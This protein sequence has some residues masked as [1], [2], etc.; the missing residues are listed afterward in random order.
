MNTITITE[1]LDRLCREFPA[2]FVHYQGRR[3]PLKVGIFHD[4]LD[5]LG[6]AIDQK[7]LRRALGAY[8]RNFGYLRALQPGAER[9]NLA[10]EPCATVSADEA[11][12]AAVV[13]A[14]LRAKRQ[15]KVAKSGPAPA[16][17]VEPTVMAQKRD[18]LSSLREAARRR[19]EV[20]L[21][22]LNVR[23]QLFS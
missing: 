11:A 13:L 2:A 3:R 14:G 12:H 10:G 9:I 17:L 7:L 15:A 6:P 19:R 18:G 8:V 20:G 16:P 5:R 21:R 4:I 1:I 22:S 23:A